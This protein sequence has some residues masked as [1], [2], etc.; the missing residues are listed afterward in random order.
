VATVGNGLALQS[1]K[2]LNFN[3]LSDRRLFGDNIVSHFPRIIPPAEKSHK[4]NKHER[5]PP[6]PPHP[7][8]PPRPL[9]QTLYV[10]SHSTKK[11]HLLTK[12][13]TPLNS[14]NPSS[15]P[16][17]PIFTT[18]STLFAFPNVEIIVAVHHYQ[19]LAHVSSHIVQ[20]PI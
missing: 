9:F 20:N 18:S 13:V 5:T 16:C 15:T 14:F 17:P 6:I 11:L 19:T 12:S 1:C 4:I 3:S 2:V 8:S 7:N 10:Q